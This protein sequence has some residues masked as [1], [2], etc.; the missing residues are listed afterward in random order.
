MRTEDLQSLLEII[1]HDMKRRCEQSFYEEH[2]DKWGD[3]HGDIHQIIK[4]IKSGLK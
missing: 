4:D 2:R 1:K 3:Y